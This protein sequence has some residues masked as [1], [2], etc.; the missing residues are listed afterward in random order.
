MKLRVSNSSHLLIYRQS[1]CTSLFISSCKCSRCVGYVPQKAAAIQYNDRSVTPF[2]P[3][4]DCNRLTGSAKRPALYSGTVVLSFVK[5]A[6]LI[7]SSGIN[8]VL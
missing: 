5:I 8:C 2:S 3:S 4:S 1:I 7:L 6:H